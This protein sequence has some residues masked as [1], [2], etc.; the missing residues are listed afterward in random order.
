MYTCKSTILTSDFTGADKVITKL[1]KF[2]TSTVHNGEVGG[3]PRTVC[4]RGM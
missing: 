3:A 4:T 2:F 1:T